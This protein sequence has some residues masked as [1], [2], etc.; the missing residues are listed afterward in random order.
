MSKLL[1]KLSALN[2]VAGKSPVNGPVSASGGE[3]AGDVESLT[4]RVLQLKPNAAQHVA[5]VGHLLVN[6][7]AAL[8]HGSFVAWL[9]DVVGMTRSTATKYMRAVELPNI[10]TLESIGVE[11]LY[12]LRQLDNVAELHPESVLPVQAAGERKTLLEMSTRELRAAVQAQMPDRPA[13]RPMRRDLVQRY[14]HLRTELQQ[15]V[16]QLHASDDAARQRFLKL[17]GVPVDRAIE[18][19]PQLP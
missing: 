15:V 10:A 6:A 1:N 19:V 17:T 14:Q 5:E 9:S 11:K 4:E 16:E 3:L 12:I 7:K 8:G 18:V 2:E 13:R